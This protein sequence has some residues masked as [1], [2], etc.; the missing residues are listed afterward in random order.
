MTMTSG[1]VPLYFE[2]T[3]SEDFPAIV[4]LHG[5]GA[6]G[7]MWRKQVQSLSS[8]YHCL[9][10]DLPEQGQ[11]MNS[12]PYTIDRAVD[13]VAE[14]ILT[15]AL[16]KRAH[17]VGLSEGA[18]VVVAL[19]SRH[20]EVIDRAVI[21]SAILR[22]LPGSSMYT[23]GLIKLMHRWFMEPL[24]NNDWWIRLNMHYAAGIPDEN[25]DEFKRSFQSTTEDGFTNMMLSNLR[26]RLPPGLEQVKNPVLVVTGS[27]E[28][29]QMKDSARDLL[30]V[31]P[32][33][34][35]ISVDLGGNSSLAQEHNW[36]LTAPELFTQTI[37]AFIEGR[38]LPAGLKEF[39]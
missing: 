15:Q 17:V 34:K 33:A 2:S 18:Q 11:S 21:S 22:P 20:P 3:G 24:K 14:L 4:F 25:F 7:W 26:F 29:R 8:G 10:P 6:A 35:G 30:K 32:N 12:G 31:L 9:T 1:T 5:G 16:G 28:Y 13:L 36:A 38:E 23:A 39:V 37:A 19:L 27:K